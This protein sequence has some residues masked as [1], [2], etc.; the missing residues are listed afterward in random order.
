M[1]WIKLFEEF[2]DDLIELT[3]VLKKYNI[4]VDIWGSGKSKT[5]NNLLDEIKGEEC[6]LIER[7]G[8]IT[9]YIEFV[10]IKI[11]YTDNNNERWFLKEIRQEFNDGRV[12]RRNIPSSVSEK[13]KFGEDPVVAGIRGIKEELGVEIQP[14]QLSK[15]SDLHY[16]GGSLSYPGLETKYK[17]HKFICNFNH[18]QF[19]TNG[20]IEVQ[21]DK[22]TFFNWIKIN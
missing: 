2:N 9:R 18:Q 20:Y 14:Y 4:P 17:G 19:N 15:H 3:N 7:S 12:R 21:K 22:K 5:L 1:K 16:D 8:K 10:G 11:Y 6:S 13:M